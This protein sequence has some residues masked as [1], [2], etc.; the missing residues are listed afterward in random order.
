MNASSIRQAIFAQLATIPEPCGIA[1]GRS[2]NICEMGLIEDVFID[3]GKVK[4]VLCLTDPGCI[5]FS[6]LQRYIRDVVSLVD[7]VQTVEVV[8][9]TE[10]LWT[11]D[12]EM[13]RVSTL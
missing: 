9:T 10:R 5:H 3:G 4:I 12:R 8:Q 13:R 6:A 11:P 2:I 7:S 1:M